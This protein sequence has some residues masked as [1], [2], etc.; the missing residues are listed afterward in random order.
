[1]P[2]KDMDYSRTIIYRIV[3]KDT[4]ITECYVGHTTNFT[5]RKCQHKHVCNNEKSKDYNIY[6]YQFIRKTGGWDDWSMIEIEKYPCNDVN[7]ALKRERYNLELYNATLNRC[8]PSRSIQDYHKDYYEG[9][10]EKILMYYK[11]WSGKNKEKLKESKKQYYEINKDTIS[12]NRE[13]LAL[14]ECGCEVRKINMLRHQ[15]TDKHF[16]LMKK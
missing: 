10:K 4:S 5:K 2:K 6:L 11:E 3:C 15:K 14:C 12:K 8:I 13:E 7:E 1:M 16:E 9:N